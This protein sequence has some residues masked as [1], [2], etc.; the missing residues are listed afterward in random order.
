MDPIDYEFPAKPLGAQSRDLWPGF[1]R[2]PGSS[3]R[4]AREFNNGDEY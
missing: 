3:L 2:G 1:A 4:F